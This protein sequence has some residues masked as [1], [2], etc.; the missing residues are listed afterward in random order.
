MQDGSR[1]HER[2]R[3]DNRSKS[4]Q[5]ARYHHSPSTHHHLR[6]DDR[7][8][9]ENSSYYNRH[10]HPRSHHH[11]SDSRE[12]HWDSSRRMS[13][14]APH[15]R[16]REKRPNEQVVVHTAPLSSNQILQLAKQSLAK[17]GSSRTERPA[18][19]RDSTSS[20]SSS[21]PADGKGV[22]RPQTDAIT[23]SPPK[24]SKPTEDASPHPKIQIRND[25]QQ[26]KQKPKSRL[27]L[28]MMKNTARVEKQMHEIRLQDKVSEQTK[29]GC[30][31]QVD[32]K[33]TTEAKAKVGK[34]EA[35]TKDSKDGKGKD[36]KKKDKLKSSEKKGN[37]KSVPVVEESSSSED[38]ELVQVI[39]PTVIVQPVAAIRNSR[40]SSPE[41]NKFF[42]KIKNQKTAPI[43]N[44]LLKLLRKL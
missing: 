43:K 4:P 35:E 30:S 2:R 44:L 40:E 6:R 14:N 36:K 33:T 28:S 22:K 18:E 15:S 24:I 11:R 39:E 29:N 1:Y 10:S 16:R 34:K 8:P 37:S 32:E 42:T 17:N 38:L 26:D 20:S 23:T 12:R 5:H 9:K 21:S 7:S 3:S 41:V 25:K 27:S 31:S 13:H 19:P